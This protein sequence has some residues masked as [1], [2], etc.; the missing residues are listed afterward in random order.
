MEKELGALQNV[1]N[2]ATAFVVEYG[3]QI[4]GAVIILV[5]GAQIAKWAAHAVL[6]LCAR[7]KLDITV[8]KF[9]SG[10]AKALTQARISIA[11]PRLEV[12]AKGEHHS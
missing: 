7:R 10:I 6:A 4:L 5:I 1:I 9:F 11:Y 8:S 3:F 12:Y 2:T